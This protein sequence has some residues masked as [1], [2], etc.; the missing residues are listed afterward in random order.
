MMFALI[1]HN[2]GTMQSGDCRLFSDKASAYNEMLNDIRQFL[3]EKEPTSDEDI[4]RKFEEEDGNLD[5]DSADIEYFGV[6]YEWQIRE[7][8]LPETKDHVLHLDISAADQPEFFGE[9]ID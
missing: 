6:T 5:S 4:R 2:D 8:D 3:C 9:I 7:C 1:S